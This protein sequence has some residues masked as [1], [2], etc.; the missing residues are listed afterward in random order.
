M[1][2]SHSGFHPSTLFNLLNCALHVEVS[3]RH[4]IVLAVKDLLE[5]ANGV[6]H[7]DLF[8]LTAREHLRH[9]ERLTREPL[10]L[11]RRNTVNLFSGES[12]SMP[13]IAMMSCK[14][15]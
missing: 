14:S 10:D 7:R 15:L 12:S 3:F 1:R 5:A 4:V 9:A 13:K 2:G 8:A 11:A 6:R